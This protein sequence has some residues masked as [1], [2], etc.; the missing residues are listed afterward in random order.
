MALGVMRALYE[1]NLRVPDD[2]S[3]AGAD[4]VVL[5]QF[6]IPPLTTIRQD[7]QLIAQEAVQ[8]LL[9][10]IEGREVSSFIA[11]T[12]LVIRNSTGPVPERE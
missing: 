1:R 2:I 7:R 6:A 4:D 9:A 12:Q 3:L 10:L 5:S 11:P 8:R